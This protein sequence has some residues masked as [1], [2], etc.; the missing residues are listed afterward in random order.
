[1]SRPRQ[2]IPVDGPKGGIPGAF[3]GLQ[4]EGLS[5][6]ENQDC[7][8]ESPGGAGEK[9]T[10]SKSSRGR[11]LLRRLTAHR[12]GKVVIAIEGFEA[13][14]TGSEIDALARRLRAHCG[15]GGTVSGRVVELQGDQVSRIRAFLEAEGFRVS[16]ER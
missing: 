15:C 8:S 1:M 6:R 9:E 12:G 5:A 11:V 16:G 4:L 10:G 7:E 13:R 14:H 3:A 2:R